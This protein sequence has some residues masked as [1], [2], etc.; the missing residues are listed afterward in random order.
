MKNVVKCQFWTWPSLWPL[1]WVAKQVKFCKICKMYW[2]PLKQTSDFGCFCKLYKW[3]LDWFLLGVHSCF[4]CKAGSKDVKRCLVPVCGKYYHEECVKAFSQTRFEPRGF[5]CPL[6]LCSSC[7][8]ENPKSLK[9]S[10][11]RS[12][13]LVTRGNFYRQLGGN[14]LQ[15]ILQDQVWH[16]T[17]AMK[18]IASISSGRCHGALEMLQ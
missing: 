5:K 17:E 2:T 10:K 4:V 8:S 3:L 9:A 12:K 13:G 1:G 18:G 6:H 11:G 7:F 15:C 14:Q 16:F